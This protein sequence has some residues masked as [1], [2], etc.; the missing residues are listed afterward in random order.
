[1]PC[2]NMAAHAARN[3]ETVRRLL[4][5]NIPFE[6]V[7]VDDGSADG[8]AAA[9]RQAAVSH[10]ETVRPVPL[11]VNV[12]KGQALR[13]GL[14]HSR[15]THLL[16]LDGDLDLSPAMLPGFFAVMRRENA[17]IV[18]GSKRHPASR[19][20][21][22]WKRRVASAIYYGL[23]RLLVGLPVTDTQ[24]GMKLFR[25]EALQWAIDRMLVKRFAF[26]VEL[27]SIA[28][29]H[30]YRV[31]EAPIRMNFGEKVGSLT[32]ENVRAVMGDTLAIFYRLRVLRYYQSVEPVAMPEPPP[33]VSV[34]IACPAPSPYLTECLAGLARQSYRNFEIIVLPD[35]P[36]PDYPWPDGTRVLPTGRLR[37]AEKRNLGIAAARGE[38]VAFLDDD[39]APAPRWLEQAVKYF[40]RDDV[41]GVG[42]PGVTPAADPWLAQMGGRVYANPLVSGGYRFRYESDR[43]RDSDDL[44]SCNLL[45][46]TAILRELGGFRTDYWPGEDTILCS[47]IVHRLKK[48]L[49][50]DPWAVVEHHR[51]PLFLPH[52]RQVGRY[53]QHRGYFARRFPTTSRRVGY[54]LPSLFVVGVALGGAL[55]AAWRPLRPVYWGALALYAALTLLA[56]FHRRP[57]V[58]L[59]TWAGIMATHGVYGARFLYGLASRRMPREVRRFDHPSESAPASVMPPRAGGAAKEQVE[60]QA[61]EQA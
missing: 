53:A 43:V 29:G 27:L 50:Y 44:P 21:Y 35:A 38:I 19:I 47:E 8:T 5:G 57:L 46:R 23:V 49:V 45:V 28:H 2:Y 37:P 58:W 40:S 20:D 1:M 52:L 55:A 25:R 26:D 13:E 14:R 15:G 59:T 24:T 22:P 34:V 3:V 56:A 18:V 60:K 7:P 39:A 36:A 61:E 10:E 54:M 31:A 33:L 42:G 48:R 51:R 17:D 6:I 12:G 30:G 32:W 11:P 16:L 4:E 9:L 41:G